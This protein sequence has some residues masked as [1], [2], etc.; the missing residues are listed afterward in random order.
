MS[1]RE[2]GSGVKRINWEDLFDKA[3]WFL[4]EELPYIL[5]AA[6]MLSLIAFMAVAGFVMLKQAGVV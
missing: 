6:V 4:Q 2:G 1:L 5:L 3:E